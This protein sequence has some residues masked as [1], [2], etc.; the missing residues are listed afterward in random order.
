MKRFS[1]MVRFA[2]AFLGVVCASAASFMYLMTFE[3]Q[4]FG[5][6]FAFSVYH[7]LAWVIVVTTTW[8]TVSYWFY[9]A[10]GK[11]MEVAILSAACRKLFVLHII[12]GAL[13]LSGVL[14]AAV[15]RRPLELREGV[16]ALI[17]LG[18]LGVAMLE[19]GAQVRTERAMS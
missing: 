10:F 4:W 16:M 6:Q 5:N 13:I 3:D 8:P 15:N 17:G 12:S 7:S 1:N 9:R 14:L 11:P 2:S 19:R 18:C